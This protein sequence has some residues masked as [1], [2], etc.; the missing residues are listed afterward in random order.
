MEL[1]QLRYFLAAAR[2][3]NFTRAA[4]EVHIAQ[5]PFGRQI[6]ALE[7]E[8]GTQLL[9]R[10]ARG[11]SLT[12]A[13]A[14]VATRAEEI[15]GSIR[16][17]EQDVAALPGDGRSPFRIG[18]TPWLLHGRMPDGIAYLR[19]AHPDLEVS[20]SV[21]PTEELEARLRRNELD[22]TVGDEP[23]QDP[24]IEQIQL[25]EEAFVL[26]VPEGHRLLLAPA[27][28]EPEEDVLIQIETRKAW[29][30]EH[31]A[32]ALR[33]LGVRIGRTLTVTEP[34]AALALVAGGA[35]VVVVPALARRMRS[36]GIVYLP[37]PG[38]FSPVLLSSLRGRKMAV[39]AGLADALRRLEAENRFQA[40]PEANTAQAS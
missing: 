19:R 32:K 8:L 33:A 40:P 2:H 4:R 17:L 1:R 9:S 31:I 39:V 25:R 36:Q 26:A 27:G 21:H 12:P 34:G 23:S 7:A 29:R 37:L 35:G 16:R 38:I 30:D 20:L 15:L 18:A 11:M 22:L 3:L 28:W 10:E 14:L 24:A 5:P 6:A 13:G